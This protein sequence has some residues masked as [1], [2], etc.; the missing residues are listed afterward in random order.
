MSG[1]SSKLGFQQIP[2]GIIARFLVGRKHC[3]LVSGFPRIDSNLSGFYGHCNSIIS[4][5]VSYDKACSKDTG[6]HFTCVDKEGALAIMGDVEV[7]FAFQER[8]SG[9]CVCGCEVADGGVRRDQY[10]GTVWQNDALGL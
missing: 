7:S 9:A 8:L 5:S 4:S 10:D 2:R 3:L 6:H 1:G